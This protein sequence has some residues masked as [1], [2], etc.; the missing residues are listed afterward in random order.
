M[1]YHGLNRTENSMNENKVSN[2]HEDKVCNIPEDET[3]SRASN[4]CMNLNSFY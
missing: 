2:S 1:Y 4:F 3:C